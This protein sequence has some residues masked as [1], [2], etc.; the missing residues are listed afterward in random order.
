[1]TFSTLRDTFPGQSYSREQTSSASGHQ[2][3]ARRLAVLLPHSLPYLLQE[4]LHEKRETIVLA[5]AEWRQGD[6]DDVQ[7]DRKGPPR[8]RPSSITTG[9]GPGGGPR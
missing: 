9:E 7:D 4:V 6:G 3:E 8:N 5:R 1:M 2:L